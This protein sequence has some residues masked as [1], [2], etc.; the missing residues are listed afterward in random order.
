MLG[1]LIKIVGLGDKR[2]D[3]RVPVRL[4][5]AFG[6][7]RGR[8]TDLGLGGCGFYPDRAE[9]AVGDRGIMYI[10]V[11]DESILPLDV[12]VV[13][14]DEEGMIYSL[15]FNRLDGADF[16]MV[17]GAISTHIAAERDRERTPRLPMPR[18]FSEQPRSTATAAS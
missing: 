10:R 4:P 7:I 17:E 12:E 3:R 11:T 2:R 6:D 1:N 13:G 5:A 16:D 15:A 18:S 8:L 9:L 14:S